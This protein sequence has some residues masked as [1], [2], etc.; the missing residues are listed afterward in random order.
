MAFRKRADPDLNGPPRI[1]RE[2]KSQNK[3]WQRM[4]S[5]FFRRRG[6]QRTPTK[7]PASIR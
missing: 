3:H 2:R 1:S 5:L 7:I 6:P 4:C